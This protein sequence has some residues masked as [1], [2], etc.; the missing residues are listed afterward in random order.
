MWSLKRDSFFHVSVFPHPGF[1]GFW[2]LSIVRYLKE[3][4]ILH[5]A[6]TSS[7]ERSR[8]YNLLPVSI[9]LEAWIWPFSSRFIVSCSYWPRPGPPPSMDLNERLSYTLLINSNLIIT[10]LNSILKMDAAYSS[11]TLVSKYMTTR[12]HN[13]DHNMK[14][15]F[16]LPLVT[17]EICW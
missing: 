11:E 16:E 8:I 3:H 7:S 1:L 4:I 10:Q 9:I 12:C 15:N 17:R 5:I 14:I 2:T 13:W 6:Y